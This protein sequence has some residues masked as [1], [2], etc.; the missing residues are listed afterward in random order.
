MVVL[1]VVVLLAGL[2]L[3]LELLGL[4]PN[5]WVRRRGE[6]TAPEPDGDHLAIPARDEPA[7]RDGMTAEWGLFTE[8]FVRERLRALEEELARLDREPG[9]FARAFHTLAARAAYDALLVEAT[10]LAEKPWWRVGE[11][12]DVEVLASS[13]GPREVLDL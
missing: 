7:D 5:R 3:P 12:V 4:P 11:V 10:T 8:E 9:V 2:L 6:G 13:S 1:L